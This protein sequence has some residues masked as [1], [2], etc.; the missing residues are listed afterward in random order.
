MTT[1]R[2]M[3]SHFHLNPNEYDG[4]VVIQVQSKNP[5][6]RRR[7]MDGIYFDNY[8]GSF[9]YEATAEEPNTVTLGRRLFVKVFQKL[10]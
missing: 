2:E 5:E 1:P 8:G 4:I 7:I 10:N 3:K 9:Q 6:V